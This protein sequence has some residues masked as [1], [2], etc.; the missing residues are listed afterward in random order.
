MCACRTCGIGSVGGGRPPSSRL[1]QIGT[2]RTGRASRGC[3]A[4]GQM[5]T[6]EK[7]QRMV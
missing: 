6:L 1:S 2:A 5:D 4:M 7:K 3:I